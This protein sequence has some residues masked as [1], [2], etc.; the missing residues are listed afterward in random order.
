[1]VYLDADGIRAAWKK[2]CD[3]SAQAFQGRPGSQVEG[4]SLEELADGVS[5]AA[6]ELAGLFKT[7]SSILDETETQI[8]G[9]IETFQ[10]TDEESAG[11]FNGVVMPS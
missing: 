7:G 3:Q 9:C 8:E 2:G 10:T 4:N 1:M 5:W 6:G 11:T